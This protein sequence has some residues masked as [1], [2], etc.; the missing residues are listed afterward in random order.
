MRSLRSHFILLKVQSNMKNMH[1]CQGAT[2]L[3]FSNT[4]SPMRTCAFKCLNKLSKK[5]QLKL[6][7]AAYKF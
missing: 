5:V 7:L 3:F 2:S 6:F 4:S 1:S